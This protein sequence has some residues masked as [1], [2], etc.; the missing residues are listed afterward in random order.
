MLHFE[1][2]LKLSPKR[3]SDQVQ[4]L[5]RV[6]NVFLEKEDAELLGLRS[7]QNS[8]SR[9]HSEGGTREGQVGGVKKTVFRYPR[10]CKTKCF[11][12]SLKETKI[13]MF[14]SEQEL[15]VKNGQVIEFKKE[16]FRHFLAVLST[17][18]LNF[19]GFHLPKRHRKES[20][21][22]DREIPAAQVKK[23]VGSLARTTNKDFWGRRHALA[24]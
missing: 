6:R 11:V 14:F 21:A 2:S 8:K 15:W 9:K 1:K 16:V 23:T 12:W 24:F 7:C 5:R 18:I 4:S 19:N 3:R 13:L 20:T 10:K 17:C 22:T